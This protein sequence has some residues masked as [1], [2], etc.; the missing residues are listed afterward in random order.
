MKHENLLF[1]KEPG[2]TGPYRDY[3]YL[4]DNIKVLKN[5]HKGWYWHYVDQST[6]TNFNYRK[7]HPAGDYCKD[8][9][10]LNHLYLRFDWGDIEQ[11]EGLYNWSY[12]DDIINEWS[13]EGYKF[14]LRMCTSES[15]LTDATP[16][17]VFRC[18]ARYITV[19]SDGHKEPVFDDPIYLEKLEKF[20]AE[21]SRKFNGNPLIELVDVGTYGTWGEGHTY[22]G[23]GIVYPA[24]TK[25]KH[26]NLHLKYFPDSYILVNDDMINE[27]YPEKS[28][29]EERFKLTAYCLG[30]GLGLRDDSVYCYNA[31]NYESLRSASFYPDFADNAPVDIESDH[32]DAVWKNNYTRG[33]FPLIEALKTSHATFAGFHGYPREFLEK[34]AYVADY[35]ANRLGYWYFIEG[36]K[37]PE[38][39]AEYPTEAVIYM[40]NRGWSAAYHKYTIKVAAVSSDGT[41]YILNNESPDNR[42]WKPGEI[43]SERI[44]LDF[45]GVP[46][47]KYSLEIGLFDGERPVKL[48]LKDECGRDGGMYDLDEFTVEP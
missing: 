37:L 40:E 36:I 9:P 16:E 39:V 2:Q 33:Y 24:D 48:A 7:D 13:T 25:M 32:Q 18:G 38:C 29:P 45:R 46:A 43:T 17:W 35:C 28:S 27:P 4:A 6:R 22:C 30:K 23:S 19:Q 21:Y 3:R 20:M 12:L 42:R 5:P 41:K 1:M 26:I 44:R 11:K 14:S 10:G 15:W 47:G 31:M 8:F 34:Y